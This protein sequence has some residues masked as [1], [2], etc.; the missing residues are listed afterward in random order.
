M[1][2]EEQAGPSPGGI[3]RL[4]YKTLN[5]PNPRLRYTAGPAAQ[6]AAVWLKRALPYS[7]IE[8]IMAG[9]YGTNT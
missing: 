8:K 1:A 5:N 4:L 7:V 3:A 6:R 2:T 9:A